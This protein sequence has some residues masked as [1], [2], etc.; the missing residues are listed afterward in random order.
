MRTAALIIALALSSSALAQDIAPSFDR[1]ELGLRYWLSTG[2]NKHAHNAQGLVPSLGNPTSVL[3]Y[4]NLD[5]HV[6]EV[7]GRQRFARDWFYKGTLGVGIITT[8]SFDDEDYNAGQVKFSDTTSSVSDG[9]LAYGTIDVGHQWVLKEG[10]VNLGVFAGFSRWTEQ[11]EA[12]GLTTTV[13]TSG[14]IDRSVKVIENKLTWQALRI[15]FAGQWI[16]GR[17][18]LAADLA[19]IP[20]ARYRNEDSHLLRQ[21]PSDLGPA[22]NI[23]LEGDGRG[24]QLDAEFGYQIGKRTVAALGW[25]Y[26]YLE[27]TDGQRSLPNF[28]SFPELPVTE[29]YS[30]RTGATLSVRHLW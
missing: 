12:S 11:V 27:S 22:P 7:F 29:L 17:A 24:V 9:W 5:A 30:K 14:S 4:E 16:I 2:E 10:A 6:L 25:R 28:P 3:L 18:R 15:G 13:G 19:L 20:Y 26:W 1:A 8:G 23:L 21:S